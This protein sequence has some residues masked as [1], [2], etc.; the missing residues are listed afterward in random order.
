MI[1]AAHA[2]RVFG[3][4]VAAVLVARLLAPAVV[5]GHFILHRGFVEQPRQE[6]R[7][8]P[9]RGRQFPF[10]VAEDDRWLIA[11]HH[12]LE[13]RRHVLGDIARLVGEPQR[14]VPLVERIV[15]AGLQPLGADGG[16]Q[17]SQQVAM[18]PDLDGVPGPSPGLRGFAAGPHRK[19]FV[20]LRGDGDVFCAGTLEH[21]RPVLRIVQFG[22]KLRGEVLVIV[23]GAEHA[24]VKIP[25]TR[26]DGIGARFAAFRDG[27]PVPFGVSQLARQ[28]RSVG[29]HRVHAPMD[30]DAEFGLGEPGRRGPFVDG[31]PGGLVG[32]RGKRRGHEQYEDGK[33]FEHALKSPHSSL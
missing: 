8:V 2:G 11:R 13:L 9:L 26:V 4:P 20:V 30:E 28:N 10:P 22:A 25:G 16:G 7:A 1:H 21:V 6:F 18:R 24:L 33:S 15:D 17:I 29:R 23:I 27:V 12:V 3:G 31:F 32:L 5:H 19:P 14:V